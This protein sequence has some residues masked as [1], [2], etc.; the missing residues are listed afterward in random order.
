MS[1]L[2]CDMREEQES[3]RYKTRKNI[4]DRGNSMYEGLEVGKSWDHLKSSNSADGLSKV[5]EWD[6]DEAIRLWGH[7]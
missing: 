4:P 5:C 1:Y 7:Y 3:T 6:H 2:S